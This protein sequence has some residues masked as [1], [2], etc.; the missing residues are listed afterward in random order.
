[1]TWERIQENG[2]AYRG[3]AK[4]TWNELSTAQLEIVLGDDDKQV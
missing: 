1:M 2:H 3:S 4:H